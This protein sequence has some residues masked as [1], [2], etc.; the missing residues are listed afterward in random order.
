MFSPSKY[1]VIS[2]FQII[3]RPKSLIYIHTKFR[4][5]IYIYIYKQIL[6]LS[7]H[8]YRNY[9]AGKSHLLLLCIMYWPI[10]LCHI[11]R[12]YHVNGTIFEKSVFDMF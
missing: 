11:F 10:W 7:I 12:N 1:L 8:F 5:P 2:D 3:F 9:L 4:I 6:W